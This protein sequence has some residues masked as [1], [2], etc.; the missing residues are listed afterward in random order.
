M[1]RGPSALVRGPKGDY[2]VRLPNTPL[3]LSDD[4][5]TSGGVEMLPCPNV[6]THLT[7]HRRI[8]LPSCFLVTK[9]RPW[10][11]LLHSF[12]NTLITSHFPLLVTVSF[13][14][15]NGYSS[16][17]QPYSS[18][19]CAKTTPSF[20]VVSNIAT[21]TSDASWPALGLYPEHERTKWVNNNRARVNKPLAAR[22]YSRKRGWPTRQ[23]QSLLA[24]TR[25]RHQ[26]KH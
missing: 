11:P 14:E 15:R 10:L 16:A 17:D 19:S 4:D 25:A 18:S 6:H 1:Y 8:S 9:L 23:V 7:Y 26:L 13:V 5:H 20:T 21:R 24:I 3:V 2:Y 12:F 22:I